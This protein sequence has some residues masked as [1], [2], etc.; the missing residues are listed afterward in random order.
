MKTSL[1]LIAVL[2]LVSISSIS[3]A[4]G[5]HNQYLKVERISGCGNDSGTPVWTSTAV[6]SDLSNGSHENQGDDTFW[7]PSGFPYNDIDAIRVKV[8]CDNCQFY[9]HGK[10]LWRWYDA[11]QDYYRTSIDLGGYYSNS[12][13]DY[14]YRGEEKLSICNDDYIQNEPILKFYWNTAYP[15]NDHKWEYKMHIHIE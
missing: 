4:S 8:K 13:G 2:M 6:R 15:R 1:K 3:V 12:N 9:D 10:D 7:T 5:L 14:Y 11:V